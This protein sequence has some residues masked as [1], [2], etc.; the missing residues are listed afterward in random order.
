M[1]RLRSA[2]GLKRTDLTWHWIEVCLHRFDVKLLGPAVELHRPTVTSLG[3]LRVYVE[4][5]PP[6]WNRCRLTSFRN[7]PDGS[8]QIRIKVRVTRPAVPVTRTE[9]DVTRSEVGVTLIGV[10]VIRFEVP[11]IRSAVHFTL[12]GVPVTRA[13]SDVTRSGVPVIRSEVLVSR[14]GVRVTQSAVPATGADV[15]RTESDRALISITPSE[16]SPWPERAKVRLGIRSIACR[17]NPG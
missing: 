1:I 10:P 15:M 6:C 11:V 9:A 8:R 4:P 14:L 2:A 17:G 13:E 16:P 3:P 7:H 5:L 12:I